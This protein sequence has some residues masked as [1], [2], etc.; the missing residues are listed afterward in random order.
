MGNH[1][2]MGN[3]RFLMPSGGHDDFG[4]QSLHRNPKAL[5][6][7]VLVAKSLQVSSDR[8]PPPN[9]GVLGLWT[10]KT[11]PHSRSPP[12]RLLIS[13]RRADEYVK[14]LKGKLLK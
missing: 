4:F 3:N 9:K 5:N 14:K 13:V 7:S 6:S 10:R 1:W 12:M 2:V 8:S 11:L